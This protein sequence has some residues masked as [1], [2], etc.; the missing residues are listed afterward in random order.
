MPPLWLAWESAVYY[1]AHP[2]PGV[3][4]FAASLSCPSS[5]LTNWSHGVALLEQYTARI[6]ANKK[7]PLFRVGLFY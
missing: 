5:F 4:R 1:F 7:A 2:L 3:R 6:A